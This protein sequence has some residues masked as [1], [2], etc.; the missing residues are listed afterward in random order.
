MRR[1]RVRF[2]DFPRGYCSRGG[3]FAILFDMK[4]QTRFSRRTEATPATPTNALQPPKKNKRIWT[5]CSS[6]VALYLLLN[7]GGKCRIVAREYEIIDPRIQAE[8]RICIVSDLHGATYGRNQQSLLSVIENTRPD[9]VLLLGDLFDQHG[10]NSNTVALLG[11]L[12]N[13]YPCYFILGNHEY[14]TKN[15]Q[16]V[17]AQIH[18]ANIPILAGT[19]VR[20]DSGIRIF[21]VDDGKAGKLKQ[22]R[23][24]REAGDE[25]RDT[26]Y[27]I[28]AIHVPNGVESYLPYSFDLMLSGHTHGGQI[29]LPG[30]L[31]GLYAPGQGFFPKY[32]GGQYDLGKTTLIISRGLSRKPFWLPRVCNP[33]EVVLV[34]CKP[35]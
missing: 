33:P 5:F 15:I 9:V 11:E 28:L 10:K 29:I 17:L 7:I 1:S 2:V 19:S 16:Q 6:L 34:D 4:T 23:Q 31:N 3:R 30:L 27:S 14:K 22:L 26:E 32:T 12:S 8:T 13:R 21:G 20:L 18:E 24:I 25:R 35:V